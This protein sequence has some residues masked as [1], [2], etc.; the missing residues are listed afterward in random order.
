MVGDMSVL[1]YSSAKRVGEN[2]VF[3]GKARLIC[4]S[5][6]IAAEMTGLVEQAVFPG[7]EA[8][9]AVGVEHTEHFGPL[10]LGLGQRHRTVGI[11]VPVLNEVSPGHALLGRG[12][13]P[14]QRRGDQAK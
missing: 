8:I 10:D 7:V 3:G 13:G 5:L 14:G 1:A 12:S 11:Y 6:M 4:L 9:I 2:S